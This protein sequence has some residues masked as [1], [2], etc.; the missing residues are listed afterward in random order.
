MSYAVGDDRIY[1]FSLLSQPIFGL[2]LRRNIMLPLFPVLSI[3]HPQSNL[4]PL[5]LLFPPHTWTQSHLCTVRGGRA[6][7]RVEWGC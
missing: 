7:W 3:V 5:S 4:F 6:S 1:G 2:S